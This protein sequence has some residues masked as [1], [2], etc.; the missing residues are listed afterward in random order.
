MLEGKPGRPDSF[1]NIEHVG[2]LWAILQENMGMA[3]E[4][5]AASTNFSKKLIFTFC[6]E[7]YNYAMFVADGRLMTSL[8]N[9]ANKDALMLWMKTDASKWSD[10]LNTAITVDQLWVDHFH[11]HT[12]L[13]IWQQL[14]RNTPILHVRKKSLYFIFENFATIH[15]KKALWNGIELDNTSHLLSLA[16][17]YFFAEN[18]S[19][20]DIKTVPHLPYSPDITPCDFLVY[21]ELKRRYVEENN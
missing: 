9:K 18:I 21:P 16:C 13:P 11:T 2:S 15:M 3:H 17:R 4:D 5:I 7:I 1:V 20:W 6:A 10:F 8:K 12:T 19:N 14:Y